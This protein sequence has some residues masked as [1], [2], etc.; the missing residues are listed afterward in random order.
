MGNLIY[1]KDVVTLELSEE[2]CV[3]CGMC[4]VVCPHSVFSMN[5]DRVQIKNRD[6]CM[7]CGAC[8]RNCPANALSVNAGVGCAAA[9]IN[10][11]LGRKDSCCCVVETESNSCC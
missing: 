8:S 7:E 2:K 9:V 1:L 10:T 6:A 3:G 11:A 5:T 4:L